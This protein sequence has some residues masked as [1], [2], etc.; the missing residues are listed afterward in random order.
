MKLEYIKVGR[1]VN[2]HGIRGDLRVQPMGQSP[3][4]L[5]HFKTLYLDGTPVKP[6]S[7]RVH[8]SLVLV[9]LPGI[10][11]MDA[12][13]AMKGKVISILRRRGL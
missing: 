11:D 1:V 7:C 8:K 9:K 3:D 13:L 5:T 6:E 10:D 2:A 12:A 4:F